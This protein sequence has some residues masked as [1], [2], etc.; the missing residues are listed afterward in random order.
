MVVVFLRNIGKRVDKHEFR[1][2]F[3]QRIFL[4][5]CGIGL[6]HCLVVVVE[7]VLI[8]LSIHFLL[9]VSHVFQVLHIVG[10]GHGLAILRLGKVGQYELSERLGLGVVFAAHI[11][12]IHVIVSV[13]AIDVVGVAFE[14]FVEFGCRG[15]IVLHLVFENDAHVI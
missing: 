14:Q 13:E 4:H 10:V 3:R 11:H 2:D 12:E 15:I 6:V 1:H 8:S 5:H 9:L 7:I